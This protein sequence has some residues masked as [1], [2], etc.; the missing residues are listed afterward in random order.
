MASDRD[1]FLVITG[2]YSPTFSRDLTGLAVASSGAESITSRDVGAFKRLPTLPT[3]NSV[4]YFNAFST[5]Q[6]LHGAGSS[7]GA[8][9]AV[10][11]GA[12]LTWPASSWVEIE[13]AEK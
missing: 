13:A 1:S 4:L 3:T 12:L 6:N 11:N 5:D 10:A 8:T 2:M 9:V 7:T